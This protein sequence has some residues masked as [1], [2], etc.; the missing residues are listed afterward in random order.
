MNSASIF[1][2]KLF[3][4]L[5]YLHERNIAHRDIK[6]ENLIVTRKSGERVRIRIVDFGNAYQYKND[7]LL[8]RRLGSK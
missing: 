8:T 6:L 5:A 4:A 2:K 3:S 7:D 1:A